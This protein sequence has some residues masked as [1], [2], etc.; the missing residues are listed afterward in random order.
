MGQGHSWSHSGCLSA[1][2]V[3]AEAA[4]ISRHQGSWSLNLGRLEH[5]SSGGSVG[6]SE[7]LGT[8]SA[9]SKDTEALHGA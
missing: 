8:A 6:V 3:R 5:S 9:S 1:P 4:S 2:S 7:G